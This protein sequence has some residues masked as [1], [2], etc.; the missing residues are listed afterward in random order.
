MFQIGS[1]VTHLVS[2]LRLRQIFETVGGANKIVT[3]F[4]LRRDNR[5]DLFVPHP[6]RLTLSMGWTHPKVGGGVTGLHA[7]VMFNNSALR[8]HILAIH[9][10]SALSSCFTIGHIFKTV[11]HLD[12]LDI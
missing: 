2:L 12:Q 11:R 10:K 6:F 9:L 3:L 7:L 8:N 4:L 1:F 5:S